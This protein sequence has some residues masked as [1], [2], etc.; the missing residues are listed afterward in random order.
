[1]NSIKKINDKIQVFAI[2][3]DG[4]L[5]ENGNGT[6]YLPA[7]S[8]LR[9]LERLG[10]KVI[11]VTGRS[12]IEAY[13]L[14]IFCGTT[15]VAVGENGGVI[16]VGPQKDIVLASKERCEEGYNILKK[17]MP[18]VNLKPVFPRKSEVVLARTFDMATAQSILDENRLELYLSDSKYAYHIN[19]KGT[20]K[21]TGLVHA[22]KLLNIAHGNVVAIGD[23][24]TD[25]PLF[26]RSAYSIALAHSD[27]EV[28]S[29]ANYVAVG[30]AGIGLSDAIDH[31]FSKLLM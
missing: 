16:T 30:K 2:D 20:N 7:V 28:K 10:F 6:I 19:Q 31:A 8:K 14:S 25:V 9:F 12:S 18:N 26:E 27:D 22:L 23:S 5:T 4:T 15:R 24:Q 21:A 1:M 29:K 17:L 11:F 13:I 3:I